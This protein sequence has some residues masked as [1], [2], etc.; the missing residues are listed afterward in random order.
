MA[1]HCLLR[2]HY[3]AR[4]SLTWF[5]VGLES[6][7]FKSKAGSVLF[8]MEA[9]CNKYVVFRIVECSYLFLGQCL[10]VLWFI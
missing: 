6:D 3:I 10:E 4:V 2:A 7:F 5:V 8:I 1:V 9:D